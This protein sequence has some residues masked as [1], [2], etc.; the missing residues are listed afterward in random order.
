[1]VGMAQR[2]REVE[3]NMRDK[4]RRSVQS[5]PAPPPYVNVEDA[6]CGTSRLSLEL[7]CPCHSLG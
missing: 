4:V 1:M 3:E 6:R 7:V 2:L 5:H